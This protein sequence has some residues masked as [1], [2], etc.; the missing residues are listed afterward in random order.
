MRIPWPLFRRR[1]RAARFR[2]RPWLHCGGL[3]L[4]RVVE[5]DNGTDIDYGRPD[6]GH[7]HR[8][9]QGARDLAPAVVYSSR[10]WC[11]FNMAGAGIVRQAAR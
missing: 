7:P 2:N 6:D 9:P 5:T 4:L 11:D 3:R 1:R 10:V 8:T